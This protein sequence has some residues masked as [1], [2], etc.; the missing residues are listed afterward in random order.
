MKKPTKLFTTLMCV[1]AFSTTA[2]AEEKTATPP[3]FPP[4]AP[5]QGM[6]GMGGG[7]GMMGGISEEQIDAHLRQMQEKMLR[8]YDFMRKIR[9]AK[10]EKEQT[11]L[12]EEWLQSMKQHMKP[13]QM[14]PQ[15]KMHG[16]PEKPPVK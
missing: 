8:D 11:K 4:P 16:M 15:L 6:A 12:K 5:H 13:P 9:E 10:D 14:P 2:I 7:M 1:A 3:P